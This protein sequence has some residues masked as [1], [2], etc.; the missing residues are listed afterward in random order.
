MRKLEQLVRGSTRRIRHT[1][2]AIGGKGKGREASALATAAGSSMRPGELMQQLEERQYLFTITVGA[3][4]SFVPDQNRPGFGTVTAFFGYA[5]PQLFPPE[6][7]ADPAAIYNIE[8]RIGGAVITLYGAIGDSVNVVD[9][10]GREMVRTIMVGTPPALEPAPTPTPPRVRSPLID[11][12]PQAIVP[13]GSTDTDFRNGD[14]IPD[15]N[16]GIGRITILQSSADTQLR[17]SGGRIVIIGDTPDAQNPA[18]PATAMPGHVVPTGAGFGTPSPLGDLANLGRYGFQFAPGFSDYARIEDVAGLGHNIINNAGTL[19]ITGL[20]NGTGAVVIGSPFTYDPRI[21]GWVDNGLPNLNYVT[22]PVNRPL[23]VPGNP[24]PANFGIDLVEPVGGGA[25]LNFTGVFIEDGYVRNAQGQAIGAGP[26]PVPV[27]FRRV[28]IATAT[29]NQAMGAVSVDGVLYGTSSFSGSLGQFNAGQMLGSLQVQ[30]D[31]GDININGNLGAW[32]AANGLGDGNNLDAPNPTGSQVSITGT[33]RSMRVAGRNFANILVQGDSLTGRQRLQY[34]NYSEREFVQSQDPTQAGQLTVPALWRRTI[35]GA[36]AFGSVPF[37]FGANPFRND[38]FHTAEFVGSALRSVQISGR[39]GFQDFIHDED[40]D[41]WYSFASEVGQPVSLTVAWPGNNPPQNPGQVYVRVFDANGNL[42][43]APQTPGQD[44]IN[45]TPDSANGEGYRISFNAPVTGVYYIQ[46]ST[47]I[48][49]NFQTS[50]GYTMTLSGLASVTAGQLWTGGGAQGG[51]VQVNNGAV[52]QLLRGTGL[53]AATGALSS[54]QAG[55][56]DPAATPVVDNLQTSADVIDI[57]GSLFNYTSRGN[58][59]GLSMFV[60]RDVG[61]V[62]IGGDTRS[63]GNL[64]G[65]SIIIGGT[66][67]TFDVFANLSW[68]TIPTL[69]NRQANTQAA[70]VSI[71]TGTN[72]DPG[73]IGRIVVGSDVSG[74]VRGGTMAGGQFTLTTSNGSFVDVF[75]VADEIIRGEPTFNMGQ[76]SDIRFASFPASE[77][78]LPGQ[79]IQTQGIPIVANTALRITD[80]SGVTFTITVNTTIPAGGAQQVGVVRA[81][82]AGAGLAVGRI[83]VFN[84]AQGATVTISSTSPGRL[85]LGDVLILGVGTTA[86]NRTRVVFSGS[87]EID[88]R[89]LSI[90]G[91]GASSITNTTADGDIVSLDAL[92][93]DTVN[94]T[95]SLGR[96]Q[97]AILALRDQAV[98]YLIDEAGLGDAVGGAIGYLPEAGGAVSVDTV[99]LN[100]DDNDTGT[101]S[102]EDRGSALDQWLNG[103]VV[104]G[105]NVTLISA[106]GAV[107]D[108]ITSETTAVGRIIANA[109]NRAGIN[110]GFEGINGSVVVGDLNTIDLGDG[111]ADNGPS[112][113]AQAGIFAHDDISLVTA[114]RVANPQVLGVIIAANLF[115]GAAAGQ[116]GLAGNGIATITITGGRVDGVYIGVTDFNA[117]WSSVRYAGTGQDSFQGDGTIGTVTITNADLARSNMFASAITTVR[118][119]NG[120][121]DA[122]SIAAVNTIG[123]ITATNLRNSTSAF[124]APQALP[125]QISAGQSLGSITATEDIRELNLRVNGFITGTVQARNIAFS[126]FDVDGGFNAIVATNDIRQTSVASSRLTRVSAVDIR[127]SSF[128]VTGPIDAVSATGTI[129]DTIISSSGPDGRIGGVTAGLNLSGRV[130]SS[131]TVGN[132]T[133]QRGS[134]I[135]DLLTTDPVDSRI[136]LVQAAQDVVLTGTLAAPIVTITAGRNFGRRNADGSTPDSIVIPGD[137]TSITATGV[138][139]TDIE[140]GGTLGTVRSGR[141]TSFLVGN[142]FASDSRIVAGGRINSVIWDGDFNGSIVSYSGGIGSVSI[143]NGSFR[144]GDA[145]QNRIE[146][147]AGDITTVTITRGHLL[148]DILAPEGSIGTVSVTGDAIFGDIGLNSALS[149]TVLTGVTA[150]E[151]RAQRPAGTTTTGRDGPSIVAGRDIGTINAAG[152]IF[153][154][155]IS[156]G[157]NI[158]AV[159]AARGADFDARNAAA[160]APGEVAQSAADRAAQATAIIAR[161]LISTVNIGLR[162]VQTFVGAGFSSLG[163]GNLIGGTGAGAD[164]VDAGRI[165]TVLFRG[166]AT[167]TVISAGVSA[168]AD[169]LYSTTG[170]NLA[171]PG[172]SSVTTINVTSTVAAPSTNNT[173]LVDTAGGSILGLANGTPVGNAGN[174]VFAAPTD[175]SRFPIFTGALPGGAVQLT[176]AGIALTNIGGTPGNN[177]VAS[178]S[179]PG[180]AHYDPATGRIILQGSTTA[181]TLRIL[182]P[183]GTPTTTTVSVTGLSVVGTDD[184]SLGT[185]E[186]RVNL[187]NAANTVALDGSITSATVRD[188][189]DATGATAAFRVA[190]TIGTLTVGAI[191]TVSALDLESNGVT[192][193]TAPGTLGTTVTPALVTLFNLGSASITG[194]FVGTVSVTRDIS[195][196]RVTREVINSA[197]RAGSAFTSFSAGAITGSVISAGRDLTTVSITGAGT[198]RGTSTGSTFLAGVDLGQD[199]RFGGSGVNADRVLAGRINAFSASG[200]FVRSNIAAGLYRGPDAFLGTPDDRASTGIS[201]I[202]TVTITGQ[203][204]GTFLNSEAYRIAAAGPITSVRVAGQTFTNVQNVRVETRQPTPTPLQVVSATVSE[205]AGN[206]TLRLRFNQPINAVADANQRY[207]PPAGALRI[208][209]LPDA[210][211]PI[212]LT[213]TDFTAT[214]DTATNTILV[215]INR[216]ITGANLG[217]GG[218]ILGA[219]SGSYR[220]ELEADVLRGNSDGNQLDGNRDSLAGDDFNSVLV[221]GDAGD[222]LAR[223]RV[224]LGS[225]ANP[226]AIIDLYAPNNIDTVLTQ[227]FAPV[228]A[229]QNTPRTATIS[230]IM[231]DH[232]DT[233]LNAFNQGADIDLYTITLQAGQF[234]SLSGL[235]GPASGAFV[236]LLDTTGAD[237]ATNAGE[238]I[239]LGGGRLLILASGTY[240]IMVA[241]SEDSVPFAADNTTIVNLPNTPGA[242]GAYSFTVRVWTDG[243]TGFDNT[244]NPNDLQDGDLTAINALAPIGLTATAGVPRPSD[245]A[246]ANGILGDGDDLVNIVRPAPLASAG[247]ITW[248]YNRGANNAV[249]GNGTSAAPSDDLILGTDANGRTYIRAAGADGVFTDNSGGT[250]FLPSDDIVSTGNTLAGVTLAPLPSDFAGLDRTLG[251]ADDIATI[252]RGQYVWTLD[253]GANN[254]F[255]GNGTLTARS[256]DLVVGVNSLYGTRI[257]RAAGTDGVFASSGAGVDRRFGTVDDVATDDTQTIE[258]AIG[259]PNTLGPAQGGS[260]VDSDVFILNNGQPMAAGTR[261]RITLN[262]QEYGN[263]LALNPALAQLAVFEIPDGGG[264]NS[265]VLVASVDNAGLVNARPN[266]T[267][268]QS[269]RTRVSYDAEG[270]TVLEL[271]LPPSLADA[272]RSGRFAV[273]VQGGVDS[274][275]SLRIETVNGAATPAPAAPTSQVFFIETNGASVSWLDPLLRSEL[276]PF[277]GPTTSQIVGIPDP[278]AREYIL[279]NLVINLNNIFINANIPISFTR[280]AQDV[281]G[282]DSSTIIL[283]DTDEPAASFGQNRFGAVERADTYNSASTGEGIVFAPPVNLLGITVDQAGLDLYTNILTGAVVRRAMQMMGLRFTAA[284]DTATPP[285]P[286]TATN[287]PLAPAD[288]AFTGFEPSTVNRPLGGSS[289]AVFLLGTQNESALLRRI[290]NLA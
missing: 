229:G 169:G 247:N 204:I 47:V 264:V 22:S 18:I 216:A 185:F 44:S 157:R 70:Q 131:G 74:V 228:F 144:A 166:S 31:V 90:F 261:I 262:N 160:T 158:T 82:S 32:H 282:I 230:G 254:T 33:L 285:A 26:A 53:S 172:S 2:A 143:N 1:M 171:A 73:H 11:Q 206:Y 96:T 163:T 109:D 137:V 29:P 178:Y 288:P 203:A 50:I 188:I 125:L 76:G 91:T 116:P 12:L 138:I 102:L 193:L 245:F 72:G 45:A 266:T 119:N 283:T 250:T 267:I 161:D 25:P 107:G 97:T 141:A 257:I 286:L 180:T 34:G 39:I 195:S 129:A 4:P 110:G 217:P 175:G 248:T 75:E 108:M 255:N 136:N 265:G 274:N 113:F 192:T 88:V 187:S 279:R 167:G 184:A 212:V 14:G 270:N 227:E 59:N 132:L 101:L 219:S 41:D 173:V 112:P 236:G 222:R 55:G 233:T 8:N 103:V 64:L 66:L 92:Q 68:L 290:F 106:N 243:D 232:P 3:D 170:D 16:D 226:V 83:E 199:A 77:L 223:N 86:A 207:A 237:L 56:I 176:L 35:A 80:D 87:A 234:F 40:R 9:L 114:T 84:L 256:D 155:F 19:D 263:A 127:N 249:N 156:A 218:V 133:S 99:P 62:L 214:Y 215:A 121:I 260:G 146:A 140:V 63:E 209:Y 95:G 277:V 174:T 278:N 105:G 202:G 210:G 130:T 159:N 177:A 124:D 52:G 21:T 42:V 165:A 154:A 190:G 117:Y 182:P 78:Q 181:S 94:V 147:R 126:T 246:G 273:Y 17:I 54:A 58:V 200:D 271:T 186:A 251:T 287:T 134:V 48:D 191:N 196:F 162:A 151:R 27:T 224:T 89:S 98:R 79:P 36:G 276:A 71:A 241:Q 122:T 269:S 258:A 164:V 201:S 153:E 38:D 81:V 49:E 179:G 128:T 149:P 272:T 208:T 284:A 145:S 65:A 28:G 194:D 268:S 280:F 57:R 148:G 259:L 120:A 10:F 23:D 104:R 220:V 168:G 231:G 239:N 275:Y 135:L 13:G 61:Q 43:A 118:V 152:G 252:T 213:G 139:Y 244:A 15:F 115:A 67:G 225:V 100:W 253:R 30:G 6:L 281:A 5:I 183:A 46:I 198:L 24:T 211:A 60:S 142:D 289:T 235:T 197:V 150:T 240:T 189:T 51:S 238:A 7:L 123:T 37:V 221:L 69:R 242:I 205:V 85:T 111:L 93:V 20:R